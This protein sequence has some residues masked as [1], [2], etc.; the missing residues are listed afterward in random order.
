MDWW[1]LIKLTLICGCST[2]HFGFSLSASTSLIDPLKY[3]LGWSLDDQSVM[4]NATI[5][6]SA[7]VGG[8]AIGSVIAGKL[9]GGGR[10]RM[11][12][13]FNFVGVISCAL[14]M[15][16]DFSAMLVGR[17]L[18]GFTAGALCIAAPKIMNETIP[19]HVADYGFGCS[20]NMMINLT[21]TL[22]LVLSYLLPSADDIP[23]L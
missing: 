13:V 8:L 9:I 7:S 4:D 2:A 17:T 3:Q 15:V 12:L 22:S 23:A 1:Y 19:P 6:S 14:S 10:K 21:I 11:I 18:Y 16:P 5:L 20:T